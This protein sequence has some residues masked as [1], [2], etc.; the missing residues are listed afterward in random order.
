MQMPPQSS[1]P[2]A[3]AAVAGFHIADTAA[4]PAIYGLSPRPWPATAVCGRPWPPRL[5]Q[6]HPYLT[7]HGPPEPPA[8]LL[9]PRPWF[10]MTS[11][12]TPPP[13]VTCLRRPPW[14]LLAP[15]VGYGRSN[16]QGEAGHG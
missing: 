16:M 5:F 13:S 12:I 3:D 7:H 8:S 15:Q 14:P 9:R 11:H 4:S 10:F 6:R 2:V 1:S